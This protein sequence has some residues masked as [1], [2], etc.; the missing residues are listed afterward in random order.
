MRQA[1]TERIALG[2]P[3]KGKGSDTRPARG[4]ACASPG[5]S[6]VLSTYNTSATCWLHSTPT[7]RHALFAD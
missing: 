7:P 4:R 2:A 5:C 6:T 3:D 1:R